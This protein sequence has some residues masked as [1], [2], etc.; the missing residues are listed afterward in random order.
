MPKTDTFAANQGQKRSRGFA[1][2][3]AS[4]MMSMPFVSI[5]RLRVA[6]SRFSARDSVVDMPTL[7]HP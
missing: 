7:W 3:S 5:R 4:V 6:A 2:R 1:V